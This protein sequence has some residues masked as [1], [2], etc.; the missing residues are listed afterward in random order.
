[1]FKRI[2]TAFF[3]LI[4]FALTTTTAE[5]TTGGDY[6]F[7]LTHPD[8]LSGGASAA[9]GGFFTA[10]PGSIAINPAL[11]AGEQ[12]IMLNLGY[13]ALLK[14]GDDFDMG[15]AGLVAL[16][17]PSR[18]GVFS[19]VV[20]GVFCDLGELNL[21]NTVGLRAGFSKDINEKLYAGVALNGG[22]R[23]AEETDWSLGLNI[24]FMYQ[25]GDLGFLR[26]VRIGGALM[27]MGKPYTWGMPSICTPR[28]GLAGTLFSA[29]DE[30]LMGGFSADLSFPQFMNAVLDVGLQVKIANIITVKSAW[31]F[32]L[33]ET[34]DGARNLIPS[35]GITVK[36]GINTK[37]NQFMAEKGW[38]QSEITTSAAWQNLYGDIHAAS[39]GAA[40]NLGLKDTS[41]PEIILW[42]EE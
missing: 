16:L 34:L 32:N 13:T 30:K 37:S 31:Q 29:A 2:S 12:R 5:T 35:V 18:W 3:C 33:R 39:I 21:K 40:I 38:Q 6:A 10:G 28:V 15:G 36:F 19:G 26:D 4:F 7:R 25:L 24:G 20:E 23:W 11:P 9:G 14:P 22:I 17:V 42:G 27:N 41:A 8:L 1:M